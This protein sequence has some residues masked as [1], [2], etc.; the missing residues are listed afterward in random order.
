[1]DE[2]V[3][4]VVVYGILSVATLVWLVAFWFV[5]TSGGRPATER[6]EIS[7]FE[8]EDGRKDEI[9]GRVEVSGMPESLL[10]SLARQM[11]Q[12]SLGGIP[13]FAVSLVDSKT[14]TFRST[15]SM[16]MSPLDSGEVRFESLDSH[17]SLARYRIVL[18]PRAR[19]LL[20]FAKLSL[21]LGFCAIGIAAVVMET[22]VIPNASPAIRWQSVQAVQ[23]VHFVWPPF[24]FAGIY[25]QRRRQI[26]RTVETM[27]HNLPVT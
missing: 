19:W 4:R 14:L 11:A 1:M 17:R 21:I 5:A 6:A 18:H 8:E 12:P 26:T 2:M 20:V 22:F 24:L 7:S 3:A 16:G 23:V 10:R 27:I 15:G 13:N 25:R 9:E